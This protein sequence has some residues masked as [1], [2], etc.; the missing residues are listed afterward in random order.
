M[1]MSREEFEQH[2]LSAY[3]QLPQEA[4]A[5]VDEGNIDIVV[6]DW[7]GPESEG[8]FDPHAGD[9]NP[10]GLFVGTPLTD[11]HG[12]QSTLLGLYV[13]IP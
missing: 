2:V 6:E 3:E 12:S 5:A 13:G 1:R 11:R 8:A 9:S 4:R 10:Q 7:P